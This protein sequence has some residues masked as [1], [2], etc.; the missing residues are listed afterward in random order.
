MEGV[1]MKRRKKKKWDRKFWIPTIVEII[2]IAITSAGLGYEMAYKADLGFALITGGSVIT[3][4]GG[5]LYA[6][7][8][9]W[10]EG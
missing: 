5:V 10:L 8:K 3:A 2:G 6:K 9:P 7:F 4:L 1:A